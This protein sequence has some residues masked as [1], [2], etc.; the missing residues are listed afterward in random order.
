MPEDQNVSNSTQQQSLENRLASVR[1]L[2]GSKRISDRQWAEFL[3][4]EEWRIRKE[5]IGQFMLLPHAEQRID[6]LVGLLSHG[7]NAGLRN[8]AIEILVGFGRRTAAELIRQLPQVNSEVRKFI[9]D[10]LGEL[11]QSELAPQLLVYLAD[12]DENVRY[13]TVETLGKLRSVVAVAPLLDLLDKA[14]TGLR[15]TIFEALAA[16]G[17]GVPVSRVS[18]YAEDRLLRRA[19][20]SCLGHLG[21]PHALETLVEGLNDPLKRHRESALL[22]IG[23]I[24]AQVAIPRPLPMPVLRAEEFSRLI[25]SYLDHS[26]AALQKAACNAVCLYPSLELLQKLLPLLAED[27]L[28]REIVAVFWRT[29][30]NLLTKLLEEVSLDGGEQECLIYLFGELRCRAI[31]PM[32]LQG[33]SATRPQLRYVCATTLGQVHAAEA[34]PTLIAALEDPDEEVQQAVARALIQLGREDGESL[35]TAMQ[36]CLQADHSAIRRLAVRVVAN[37][38]AVQVEA[39]LLL[40]LK[41]VAAEVRCE[42]L[43]HIH[44]RVSPRLQSGLSLALADEEPE[45]RRLASEAL[46]EF[47]PEDVLP[48]L[49]QACDDPD[50]RVRSAAL[51]SITEGP[52][53]LVCKLLQ[54]AL[55]DRNGMV[56]IEALESLPKICPRLA[57]Q[58]FQKGLLDDDPEVMAT[59]VRLLLEADEATE[60][61]EHPRPLVRLETVRQLVGQ[62]SQKWCALFESRLSREQ[63]GAV[64]EALKAALRGSLE[65]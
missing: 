41:D 32:A 53:E 58:G 33:L 62:D 49:T 47:P 50:P 51:R 3:G 57:Q 31:I 44:G 22:A 38:P 65:R 5:A 7:E 6:F 40:A 27:G 16:I 64:F 46:A 28:R 26:D 21:D 19:V 20:Y 1:Q 60:L 36:P 25:E 2:A 39:A 56:R 61:L 48:I 34:L 18:S 23:E 29:P 15:F 13:A 35:F 14:E 17:S 37:L 43:R 59:A 8:A 55:A 11:G 4:D 12:A 45:V 24:I 54:R 9:I 42:T 30:Q 63:D 52:E 10:I